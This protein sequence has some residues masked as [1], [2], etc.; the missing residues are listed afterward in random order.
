MADGHELARWRRCQ[1]DG[2]VNRGGGE[3]ETACGDA[4]LGEQLQVA[5]HDL[6]PRDPH[7]HGAL[8]QRRPPEQHFLIAVRIDAIQLESDGRLQI[9]GRHAAQQNVPH[10]HLRPGQQHGGA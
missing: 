8:A 9:L 1:P 5:I 4:C 2:A 6:A 10:D 7:Q 3:S